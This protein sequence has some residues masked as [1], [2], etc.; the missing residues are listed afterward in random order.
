M[1]DV[2]A[3]AQLSRLLMQDRAQ[4]DQQIV[5]HGFDCG[6]KAARR[7]VETLGRQLYAAA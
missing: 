6:R 7:Q 1:G 2:S 5:A 3:L 4:F